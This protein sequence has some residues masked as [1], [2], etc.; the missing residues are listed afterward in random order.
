MDRVPRY[1]Y[2][3]EQCKFSWCCGPTCHCILPRERYADPPPERQAE[4]DK[5]VAEWRERKEV[6]WEASTM[7]GRCNRS[8]P[9]G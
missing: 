6:G 4:V 9:E 5:A 7:N 1:R 8:N 3:C 2:D